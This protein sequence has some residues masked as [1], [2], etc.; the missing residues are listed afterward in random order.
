MPL[1]GAGRGFEPLITYQI[2]LQITSMEKSGD[3]VFNR[4]KVKGVL[5]QLVERNN[6]IVEVVGSIPTDSTNFKKVFRLFVKKTTENL[7]KQNT[8]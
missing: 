7:L 1:Q 6:G 3:A 2:F 5:A 8:L 4:R